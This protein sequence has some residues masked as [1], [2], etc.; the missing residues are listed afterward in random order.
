MTAGRGVAG[1]EEL[2]EEVVVVVG[3]RV[4][5]GGVGRRDMMRVVFSFFSG[6]S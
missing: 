6:R 4:E 5:G 1:E 3:E 2:E